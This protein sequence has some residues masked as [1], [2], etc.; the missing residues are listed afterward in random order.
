[1][2]DIEPTTEPPCPQKSIDSYQVLVAARP[3]RKARAV[4]NRLCDFIAGG[5][6]TLN[7]SP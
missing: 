2:I 4:L 7:K 6:S 3:D 1:M 5:R